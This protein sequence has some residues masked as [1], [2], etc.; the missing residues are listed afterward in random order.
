MKVEVQI[1]FPKQFEEV[2]SF[3]L[4]ASRVEHSKK[5]TIQDTTVCIKKIKYMKLPTEIFSRP[6]VSSSLA[7][8]DLKINIYI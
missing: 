6:S 7:S 1:H 4:V 2:C 3:E 8:S 5:L